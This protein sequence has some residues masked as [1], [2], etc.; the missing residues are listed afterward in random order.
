MT[1]ALSVAG[2]TTGVPPGLWGERV[3]LI[4]QELD[5]HYA[6]AAWHSMPVSRNAQAGQHFSR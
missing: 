4:L 2:T 6:L 1:S 3:G 5:G